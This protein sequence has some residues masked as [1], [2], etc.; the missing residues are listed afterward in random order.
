MLLSNA[1]RGLKQRHCLQPSTWYFQ[2]SAVTFESN[3]LSKRQ[4]DTW[5]A[6]QLRCLI[7]SGY[8]SSLRVCTIGALCDETAV[9]SPTC[10]EGGHGGVCSSSLEEYWSC[11]TWESR[12]GPTLCWCPKQCWIFRAAGPVK[13]LQT[14]EEPLLKRPN[15]SWF[16]YL[17]HKRVGEPFLLENSQQILISVTETCLYMAVKQ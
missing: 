1:S 8:S 13:G 4:G 10:S 3:M 16:Q 2:C 5:L 12:T 14:L 17:G 11:V 15:E 9:K 6:F 7:F